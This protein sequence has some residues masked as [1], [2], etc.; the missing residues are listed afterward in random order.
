MC[1]LELEAVGDNKAVLRAEDKQAQSA[2][3]PAGDSE[4]QSGRRHV[5]LTVFVFE[6]VP[7]DGEQLRV[8]RVQNKSN[9][10]PQ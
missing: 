7:E 3:L 10:Y 1:F 9:I 5:T 6:L 4:C 8:H 2:P